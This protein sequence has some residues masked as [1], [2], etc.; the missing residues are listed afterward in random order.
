MDEQVQWLSAEL[1]V[2]LAILVATLDYRLNEQELSFK[3]GMNSVLVAGLGLC[4]SW[5]LGC[6]MVHVKDLE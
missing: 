5:L 4:Q 2:V 6:M 1:P 3:D